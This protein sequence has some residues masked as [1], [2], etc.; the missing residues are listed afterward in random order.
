[1]TQK[2]YIVFGLHVPSTITGA[3]PQIVFAADEQE[4]ASF[5]RDQGFDNAAVCEATL[6]ERPPPATTTGKIT[7]VPNLADRDPNQEATA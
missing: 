1:M 2:C 6:I 4:A 7:T 3:T 5:A